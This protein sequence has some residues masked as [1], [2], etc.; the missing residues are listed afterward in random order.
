MTFVKK[1]NKWLV[2]MLIILLL[3]LVVPVAKG[4]KIPFDRAKQLQKKG[5][6]TNTPEQ[7]VEATKAESYYVRFIALELLKQRIGEK[8]IPTLKKALNDP[9]VHVRWRAAHWLGTLGDKSG[10]ERMRQDFNELAPNNGAPIPPDPNVKDPNEIKKREGKRNARLCDA[11]KVA[12][13]LAELGDRRGYEL[14]AR[15]ALQGQWRQQR[16]EAIVVLV[17][18]A[19]TDKAILQAEGI[20]PVPILCAMAKSE[21]HITVFQTLTV[22]VALDLDDDDAIR[23]LDI[24]KNSPNQSE[25]ARGVAQRFLDEVKNRKK[26]AVNKPK[27]SGG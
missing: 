19:K 27:D 7:I 3:L 2:C 12:R 4:T 20:E 24:A 6:P 17:K 21:K 15:L 10:L 16:F 5:Y 22:Y 14:A 11:I 18:I 13:V 8:A 1:T 9:K 25:E 23:V 26:A